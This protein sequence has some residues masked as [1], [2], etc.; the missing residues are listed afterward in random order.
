MPHKRLD[1][2]VA[3]WTAAQTGDTARVHALTAPLNGR[4][5]WAQR[6]AFEALSIAVRNDC[7]DAVD[8]LCTFL[9]PRRRCD[10]WQ[11]L[12]TR[13]W[14]VCW[15]LR[16]SVWDADCLRD[17]TLPPL[18]HIAV[19]CR[20]HDAARRLLE[21]GAD[22]HGR[23]A[24]EGVLASYDGGGVTA[25][26]IA[27]WA[28]DVVAVDL[29]LKTGARALDAAFGRTTSVAVM[30]LLL[31]HGASPLNRSLQHDAAQGRT[32]IVALVLEAR[33]FPPCR[34]MPGPAETHTWRLFTTLLGAFMDNHVPHA[35]RD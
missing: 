28:N 16:Q 10:R 31:S 1:K 33:A 11:V 24:A 26:E 34:Y 17:G 18:L 4:Q 30:R 21:H 32:G 12:Q 5:E 22:V 8:I 13:Q 15:F 23:Y 20:S 7:G 9:Q 35:P 19:G 3:L 2:R 27:A 14:D 25:L 6:A 29:L